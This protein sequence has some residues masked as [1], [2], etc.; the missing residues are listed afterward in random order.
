MK[1][2]LERSFHRHPIITISE[3]G[4]PVPVV[5]PKRFAAELEFSEDASTSTDSSPVI[6]TI[7]YFPQA[8]NTVTKMVVPERCDHVPHKLRKKSVTKIVVPEQCNHESPKARKKSFTKMVVAEP[9]NHDSPKGRKKSVTKVV[10]PESSNLES[11][12]ARKKSFTLEADH[13]LS[14]KINKLRHRR[15]SSAKSTTLELAEHDDHMGRLL[16]RSMKAQESLKSIRASLSAVATNQ[17][18]VSNK[19]SELRGR[20]DSLCELT[21]RIGKSIRHVEQETKDI[22]KRHKMHPHECYYLLLQLK[23]TWSVDMVDALGP[24]ESKYP[25]LMIDYQKWQLRSCSF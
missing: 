20:I 15:R 11:P 7:S 12:K 5:S 19:V 18:F 13:G 3:V 14:S 16:S 9:C 23:N 8:M 1:K 2:F 24:E 6:A 21:H 17:S 25:T 22:K 10:V 4:E